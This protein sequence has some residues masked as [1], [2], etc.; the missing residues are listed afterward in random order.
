MISWKIEP[1]SAGNWTVLGEHYTMFSTR[2]KEE[3]KFERY[4]FQ[5]LEWAKLCLNS[6]ENLSGHGYSTLTVSYPYNGTTSASIGLASSMVT[7]EYLDERLREQ[8]LHRRV[9]KFVNTW[10]VPR[11]VSFGKA[12]WYGEQGMAKC[13]R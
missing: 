9:I 7:K 5:T 1:N 13:A 10:L 6:M 2:Q 8:Q 12:L 11:V 4:Q 3:P